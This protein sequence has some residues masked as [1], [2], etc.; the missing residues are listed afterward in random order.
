M[1]ERAAEDRIN[2]NVTLFTK[3]FFFNKKSQQ[4]NT[5][6]THAPSG[7]STETRTEMPI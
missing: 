4:G 7:F 2:E 5:Q 6:E 1:R 3:L